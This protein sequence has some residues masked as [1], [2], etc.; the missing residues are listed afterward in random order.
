[1]HIEAFQTVGQS[2]KKQ[3]QQVSNVRESIKL[4]PKVIYATAEVRTAM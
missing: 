3:S 4:L 2:H 1:M